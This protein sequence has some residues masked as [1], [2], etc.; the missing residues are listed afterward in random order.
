MSTIVTGFWD[1]GRDKWTNEYKRDIDYYLNNSKRILSLTNNMIIFIEPKFK[2]FVEE[3]RKGKDSTTVI[4]PMEFDELYMN[5]FPKL[6]D[7]L[8]DDNWKNNLINPENPITNIKYI[9]LV[10]S[11]LNLVIKAIDL[12][13]FNSTHF[14]WLDYGCAYVPDNFLNS[15]IFNNIPDKIK[16]CQLKNFPKNIPYFYEDRLNWYRY[17]FQK[18]A[19]TVFTGSIEYFKLFS[20]EFENEVKYCL[21]NNTIAYEEAIFYTLLV[22]NPSLLIT[23]EGDWHEMITNYYL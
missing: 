2:N 11:K 14:C 21:D 10:L 9:T 12:N 3:C 7:I 17:V 18:I 1:I 16:L 19:G 6:K 5:K 15:K 23:Y 8:S 22:K 13:H 20:K 4:I